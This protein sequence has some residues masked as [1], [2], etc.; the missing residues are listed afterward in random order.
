MIDLINKYVINYINNESPINLP[1]NAYD[2]YTNMIDDLKLT[3]YSIN[4]VEI[5]TDK[6]Q[7]IIDKLQFHR[8]PLVSW[9]LNG[10]ENNCFDDCHIDNIDN[11]KAK[12]YINNLIYLMQNLTQLSKNRK[13]QYLQ[14]HF[15]NTT[16]NLSKE[17]SIQLLMPNKEKEL[18]IKEQY[19]SMQNTI[20]KNKQTK[21]TNKI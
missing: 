6:Q 4:E 14:L 10:E 8:I 21:Q 17:E 5:F 1:I 7:E 20:P 9:H 16:E 12:E 3:Y 2:L 11:E 19:Y 18:E 15:P 13:Y